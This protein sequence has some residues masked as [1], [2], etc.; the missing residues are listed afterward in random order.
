MKKTFKMKVI[1]SNKS[2][3]NHTV[4]LSTLPPED[5]DQEQRGRFHGN[6]FPLTFDK[7]DENYN[8]LDV[9]NVVN[10]TIVK[11]QYYQFPYSFWRAN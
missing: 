8:A 7:D 10:V 1:V 6:N 11:Q 3:T 2:E 4:Q 5:Q 9:G